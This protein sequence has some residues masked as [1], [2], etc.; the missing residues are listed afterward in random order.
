MLSKSVTPQ[1]RPGRAVG[2]LH[3]LASARFD[4]PTRKKIILFPFAS[5]VV[6]FFIDA[7]S[8]DKSK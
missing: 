8:H 4:L 6:T 3:V 5:L 7:T 1:R 2:G